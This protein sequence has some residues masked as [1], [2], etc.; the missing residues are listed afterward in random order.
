MTQKTHTT[1]VICTLFFVSLV[2]VGLSGCTTNQTTHQTT[3]ETTNSLIGTWTGSLQLSLFEAG[4]NTTMTQITFTT[5]QTNMKL[6]DGMRSFTMNYTYTTT[7]DTITLTPMMIK[8]E[9]SQGRDPVNGTIPPNGTMFPG[10]GT[11][12]PNVT[13]PPE[14]G[15]W[16]P[17][18]GTPQFNETEPRNRTHP[19]GDMRQSMTITLR[20]TV[21]NDTQSLLLNSVRF[22]KVQ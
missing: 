2:M 20:Y 1:K 13:Q 4:M 12:R 7:S 3:N 21:D 10:N 22:T 17:I 15:S 16:P 19:P 9:G 8:R 11:I 5:N 14:N 18:G 6:S